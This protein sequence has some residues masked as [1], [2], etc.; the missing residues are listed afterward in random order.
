MPSDQT[1]ILGV[2]LSL[3]TASILNNIISNISCPIEYIFTLEESSSMYIEGDKYYIELT[4]TD[5]Q[6][7][8]EDNLLH[9]CCHILQVEEGYPI[10]KICSDTND[11]IKNIVSYIQNLVLDYDVEYKLKAYGYIPVK[12]TNKYHKYLDLI[13]QIKGT[14]FAMEEYDK[15]EFALDFTSIYIF[16]KPDHC[17]RLLKPFDDKIG[18]RALVYTLKDII[19]SWSDGINKDNCSMRYE[20]LIGAVRLSDIDITYDKWR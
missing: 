1:T 4:K 10:I 3:K 18:L 16:D 12:M 9:E 14:I 7:I 13:K 17:E 11:Q 5:D 19:K 8:F 2:Q 20:E 6:K 15:I